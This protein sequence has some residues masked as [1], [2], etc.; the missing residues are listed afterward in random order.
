M[1]TE[2]LMHKTTLSWVSLD[3]KIPYGL[4]QPCLPGAIWLE[5]SDLIGQQLLKKQIKT[6]L[7]AVNV[8]SGIESLTQ[9]EN[10]TYGH[11]KTLRAWTFVFLLTSDPKRAQ[12]IEVSKSIKWWTTMTQLL[13]NWKFL[14]AHTKTQ[15]LIPHHF[16]ISPKC[17]I[18]CISSP[19]LGQNKR[20]L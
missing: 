15:L 1:K 9:Y 5:Q 8:S 2:W 4:D 17:L 13:I 10:V 16:N 18:Q 7:S 20:H 14:T 11:I 6:I 19:T 3:M 12:T